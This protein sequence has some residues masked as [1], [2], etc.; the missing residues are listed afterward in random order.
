MT[1]RYWPKAVLSG[2]CAHTLLLSNNPRKKNRK[3][4]PE[5]PKSHTCLRT[6][7]S[8]I[9]YIAERPPSSQAK[10]LRFQTFSGSRTIRKG[11]KEQARFARYP[12]QNKRGPHPINRYRPR[13]G[14]NLL[15]TRHN[16][17]PPQSILLFTR[18]YCTSLM[19]S[20]CTVPVPPV[21]TGAPLVPKPMV[22][23]ATLVR[24]TPANSVRSMTH[25]FQ[26][27]A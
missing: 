2:V 27:P 15:H 10:F 8:L 21:G 1:S 26:P 5:R 7:T 17:L 4:P 16:W 20:K 25:S 12:P 9:S 19:S 14:S 23:E 22:I 18:H 11:T 3:T 6:Q 24:S 13:I